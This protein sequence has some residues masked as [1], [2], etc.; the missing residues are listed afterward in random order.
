MT[1]VQS[2]SRTLIAIVR[3]RRPRCWSPSQS[4]RDISRRT[5]SSSL[6]RRR[7]PCRTCAR[8]STTCRDRRSVSTGESS[9]NARGAFRKRAV[10][11]AEA[12]GQLAPRRPAGAGRSCASPSSRQPVGRLRAD[13]RARG[14]SARSRSARTPPR[15]PSRR[16]RRGLPRSLQH[17]ATSRDGADADRDHD[18]GPLLDRRDHLAQHAQRLLDARQLGVRLVDARPAA[19]GRAARRHLPDALGRL[20]IG[21]EVGRDARSRPGTAGAPARPAW[22]T[23]RRTRAPRSSRS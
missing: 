4:S 11:R 21:G 14:S 12:R 6:E 7:C 2:S 16:S 22:P 19:R 5:S 10:L 15:G 18:P 13:A 17:L 9:S 8:S 20:A 23:R 1:V 3:P